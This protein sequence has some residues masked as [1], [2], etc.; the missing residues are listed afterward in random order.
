M[1]WRHHYEITSQYQPPKPT[2]TV[3]GKHHKLLVYQG[4]EI[5]QEHTSVPI[6][7][8]LRWPDTSLRYP[9]D[10]ADNQQE[11]EAKQGHRRGH[12]EATHEATQESRSANR[13][14]ASAMRCS[15]FR[16]HCLPMAEP[17]RESRQ[18]L[19]SSARPWQRRLHASRLLVQ[20]VGRPEQEDTWCGGN[21][22][23]PL[24]SAPARALMWPPPPGTN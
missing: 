3:T 6:I 15:H 13:G 10:C 24:A 17:T 18:H 11:E 14:A 20:A 23:R 4:R 22:G 2:A 5:I 8:L 12:G 1:L 9:V 7:M 21:A 16:C 19:G